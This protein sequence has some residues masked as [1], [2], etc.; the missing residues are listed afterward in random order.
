MQLEDEEDGGYPSAITDRMTE[1][2]AR[3]RAQWESE[4]EP[5]RRETELRWLQ[6]L[7]QYKSR[8]S[9]SELQRMEDGFSKVFVP[10]TKKKVNTIAARLVDMLFP[11][12]EQRNWA[13][14]PSDEP[15]LALE[16][17]QR[18]AQE[19]QQLQAQYQHVA[20]QAQ[21]AGEEPPDPP[22]FDPDERRQ[23]IAKERA[24]KMA[25]RMDSQLASARYA[26]IAGHDVIHAG[27]IYGDGFLKGPMMDMKRRR[28]YRPGPGGEWEVYYEQVAEPYLE[29]VDNW[30][31]YPDMAATSW[32]DILRVTQRHVMTR[33]QLL[34]LAEREDFRGE[35]ILEYVS[36]RREGDLTERNHDYDLRVLG[37]RSTVNTMGAKR[38]EVL[39]FWGSVP[40]SELQESDPTTYDELEE[41]L[42]EVWCNIWLLGP[43]IIK[44]EVDPMPGDVK[45]P[46]HAFHVYRD[47]TS[48][49]AEGPPDM[50][51][52]DQNIINASTR[53]LMD[54]A[55]TV[56]GPMLEANLDLLAPGE[57]PRKMWARR[58]FLRKGRGQDAQYPAVREV[59]VTSHMG[60]YLSLIQ[61]A[62]RWAHEHTVPS[63]M[64]GAP[65]SNSGA[66]GTASG[67][68]MLMGA[69]NIDL[70][71]LVR[72][73]DN[74]IT[75]PFI[76][77]L[78]SWNMEYA[79]DPEL[80]GDFEIKARGSSSLVAKEVQAESLDRFTAG[81]I[82]TPFESWIRWDE[83]LRRRLEVQDL[84]D[85]LMMTDEEHSAQ[86][87]AQQEADPE[88]FK[89][90]LERMELN[91]KQK[92]TDA[93]VA[94]KEAE[95]MKVYEEVAQM[96][97]KNRQM[98]R[99][100]EHMRQQLEA[101]T[102]GQT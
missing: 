27:C 69:A 67:L 100:N 76:S 96:R 78:Y 1:L 11:A 84:D 90:Q 85:S 16:D 2:G 44:L 28:R 58:V 49:F 23:E 59:P 71:K 20:M 5:Q 30:D 18:I 35:E 22:E 13:I 73:F 93:D 57:D 7:R 14:E 41:G 48:I 15:V 77:A 33:P 87:K 26:E 54:N 9:H 36:A 55:G 52:D 37:E 63:Y 75:K 40:V 64:E 86:M 25:K 10:I 12:A 8:Y 39:E 80:K 21:Q 6:N 32:D 38:Y 31:L 45:H 53:A 92:E 4:D 29:C 34:E 60:E 74:G 72:N 79:E 82:G 89:Q 98:E 51:A 3:L 66:Q 56:S 101:L 42:E 24:E 47:R 46:Y 83:L 99:E 94:H 81:S 43:L 70:K 17:E 102:Y 88:Q 19:Q 65:T 61:M 68:S 62:E 97:A 95:T 50:L 91:I